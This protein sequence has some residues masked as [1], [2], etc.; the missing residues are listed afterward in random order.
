MGTSVDRLR[1]E[2]SPSHHSTHPSS[3]L[4]PER[5][6]RAGGPSQP[7]P[8][9]LTSFG[10]TPAASP[11]LTVTRGPAP[12]SNVSLQAYLQRRRSSF[13]PS[14]S[15]NGTPNGHFP[16]TMGGT[17]GAGSS[18]LAPL[19]SLDLAFGN[20]VG[21]SG[22][23][24]TPSIWESLLNFN[25][26]P[27]KASAGASE[28]YFTSA[29]VMSRTKS[30]LAAGP[31]TSFMPTFV[32]GGTPGRIAQFGSDLAWK[33]ILST[34]VEVESV[35]QVSVARLLSE[36]WKRGGGDVVTN[37]CLWPSI[38]MSLAFAN[39]HSSEMRIST[40]SAHAAMSL[41]A[42]YT[43]T[44]RPC[45]PSIFAGLLASYVASSALSTVRAPQPVNAFAQG[46]H[47]YGASTPTKNM[48]E[49]D[50]SQW[51]TLTPT[52][53][54]SEMPTLAS[55]TPRLSVSSS[56]PSGLSQSLDPF[57]LPSSRPGSSSGDPIKGLDEILAQMEESNEEQERLA[58]A[59]KAKARSNGKGKVLE[60]PINTHA[61][62][63]T[64]LTDVE[65]P[66]GQPDLKRQA[67]SVDGFDGVHAFN[68]LTPVSAMASP[69]VTANSAHS[70]ATQASTPATTVS[71]AVPPSISSSSSTSVK[72]RGPGMQLAMPA[73]PFVPPPPMCMFFSPAFRDL[74][75]GKVGVWKGDLEIRGRGGG[76][77]NVLVVG[78]EGSGHFWQSHTWPEKLV[79]PLDHRP[80]ESCTA[81][82]LPVSTLAREGLLPVS[83]GMVLCND[84][85]I[86][87]FVQ[88]VQGLH[89]EGVAFHL[90]IP[91]AQLPIIFLP[92]KFD[93]NDPLQRLGIAFM[94][95]AGQSR[96][97]AASKA[98]VPTVPP[99]TAA[100]LAEASE[101]EKKKRRKSTATAV[102]PRTGA[103]RRSVANVKPKA[104]A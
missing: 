72:P 31:Q 48:P 33:T 20:D 58:Q 4:S 7:H 76:T 34:V 79:Y 91:G 62:L 1:H 25:P 85:N 30:D 14:R 16:W 90:P 61:Q 60:T 65:S 104:E 98:V 50:L 38:I 9:S 26:T 45:E 36:V 6:L 71:A 46:A 102:A 73:T 69:F 35:G 67:S 81:T 19:D 32:G 10:S 54:W 47:V 96:L 51:T 39:D 103:Q 70:S 59:A 74:Q 89:A 63:P 68:E 5:L 43:L 28:D 87:A 86:S 17:P 44:L 99:P 23:G 2:A 100:A 64:P 12:P 29:A 82:M 49:P 55:F 24:L 92:A 22:I 8:L 52:A 18:N 93:S 95:P 3:S 94:A 15:G 37:Q 42:L 56:G 66:V 84:A 88:L 21:G 83:M 80:N 57:D 101:P 78:E 41:Q 13:P 40:P 75:K 53:E 27:T 97:A 11:L 77:F